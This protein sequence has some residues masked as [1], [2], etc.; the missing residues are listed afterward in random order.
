MLTTRNIVALVAVSFMANATAADLSLG[1]GAVYNESPYHGYN[2]NTHAVPLASYESNSFYFRQT[3]LGYI[4]SKSETNEFSVTASWMPLEF[5]PSDNDDRAMRQLD[6]RDSTAMA[7]AAW[8]HHEKWG[9]LK[10]S[11]AADILNNSNGWVGEISYF[12]PMLMGKFT[13]TPSMGV[14]YY[15]ENFNQYYYGVSGSESRRSGLA[16][17]SPDDSWTPYV[18]LAAKYPLTDNLVLLAS[19][20]YSVLPDDIK[21]SPMVDRDDSFTF[22]SGVSWRF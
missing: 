19:A 18:G 4:L 22:L 14:L 6:K 17:Y 8:Y 12:R 2:K 20:T 15:D 1:A 3:T 11:A 13:L 5:D 21:K 16:G 9:S 10:V 7:G